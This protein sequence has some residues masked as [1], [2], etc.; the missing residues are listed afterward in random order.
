MDLLISLLFDAM[1]NLSRQKLFGGVKLAV[2]EDDD[3]DEED[4]VED[5]EESLRPSTKTLCFTKFPVDW[6]IDDGLEVEE[7]EDIT[8]DPNPSP[9]DVFEVDIDGEDILILDSPVLFSSPTSFSSPK[10]CIQE[11]LLLI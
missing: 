11:A 7:P 2:P 10:F 3:K 8:D 1:P 9:E 5:E 6:D 4:E